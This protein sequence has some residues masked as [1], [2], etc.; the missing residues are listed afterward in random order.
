MSNNVKIG[1]VTA[2]GYTEAERYY[3][4]LHGLLEAIKESTILS[5]SQK[6]NIVIMGR[7]SFRQIPTLVTPCADT[8]DRWRV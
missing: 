6:E 5:P 2:A 1:I 4:R 7:L 8:C 3:A